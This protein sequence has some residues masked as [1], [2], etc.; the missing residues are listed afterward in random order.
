M[1]TFSVLREEQIKDVRVEKAPDGTFSIALVSTLEGKEGYTQI[2]FATDNANVAKLLLNNVTPK[3]RLEIFGAVEE[4]M[5][6]TS[7]YGER[8]IITDADGKNNI[9]STWT[10]SEQPIPEGTGAEMPHKQW[11]DYPG[12]L[13]IP[14]A[15]YPAPTA[16]TVQAIEIDDSDELIVQPAVL[17]QIVL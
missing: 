10:Q 3:L 2:S 16:P 9:T 11:Q 14:P 6:T 4:V 13:P 15:T 5:G 7:S 8:L 1:N 12:A 17:G